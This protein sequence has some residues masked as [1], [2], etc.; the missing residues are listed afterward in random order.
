M[1]TKQRT[2]ELVFEALRDYPETRGNDAL[3]IKR[4]LPKLGVDTSFSLD[5]ILTQ[6][7]VTYTM[8]IIRERSILQ[9]KYP[10]FIDTTAQRSRRRSQQENRQFYREYKQG[11][12]R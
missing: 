1:N 3:L 5:K 12:I 8:T 11:V 10:E 9:N 2:M 7:V 4:V 6:Q